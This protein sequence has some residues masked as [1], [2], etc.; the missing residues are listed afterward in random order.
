MLRYVV[1][2]FRSHKYFALKIKIKSIEPRLPRVMIKASACLFKYQIDFFIQSQ[3][4]NLDQ[5]Q[6]NNE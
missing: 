4:I 1:V 6:V 3:A 2:L 5:K